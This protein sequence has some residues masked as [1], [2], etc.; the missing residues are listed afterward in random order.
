MIGY[1]TACHKQGA[2]EIYDPYYACTPECEDIVGELM[3][4]ELQD[5]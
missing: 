4:F 2:Y 1:C 5:I 3:E